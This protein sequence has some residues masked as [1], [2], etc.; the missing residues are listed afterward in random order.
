MCE[1]I[2]ND[3]DFWSAE[4]IN[5]RSEPNNNDKNLELLVQTKNI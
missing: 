4:Q 5:A 1:L 2:T 3:R